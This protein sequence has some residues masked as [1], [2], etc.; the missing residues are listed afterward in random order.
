[1]DHVR[2]HCNVNVLFSSAV[3]TLAKQSHMR[4][5]VHSVSH[6]QVRYSN[7]T[8]SGSGATRVPSR[9]IAESD[10]HPRMTSPPSP[11][12]RRR[13]R[14]V[15]TVGCS[16][17]R[18]GLVVLAACGSASVGRWVVESLQTSKQVLGEGYFASSSRT[19]VVVWTDYGERHDG[20]QPGQWKG[21]SWW[22]EVVAAGSSGHV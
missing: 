17:A 15:V 1:M 14:V 13:R 12:N 8:L 6:D 4:I 5:F 11:P 10:T 7:V 9:Q 2:W 21:S 19:G 20:L 3:A 22:C 16:R 18:A